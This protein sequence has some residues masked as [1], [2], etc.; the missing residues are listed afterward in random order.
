ME[1]TKTLYANPLSQL[2]GLIE[3]QHLRL[4]AGRGSA[5][6]SDI[7]AKRSMRIIDALPRHNIAWSCT[8]YATFY[9]N[10]LPALLEGWEREGWREGVH[11]VV[12]KQPPAS[13]HFYEYD[14]PYRA[15]KNY[16]NT[17][18][19][20][21]RA[22]VYIAS[23]AR[24]E[25]MAGG[26]YVHVV[27]DEVRQMVYDKLTRLLPALR[28][29]GR[30]TRSPYFLGTTFT[31]DYPDEFLGDDPW[32]LDSARDMDVGQIL[33]I[34]SLALARNTYLQLTPQDQPQRDQISAALAELNTRLENKRMDSTLF[35]RVSSFVNAPILGA[36]YF[37][38][39]TKFL[40]E[41]SFRVSV[42]SLAPQSGAGRA[43]YPSFN[44]ERHTFS[45]GECD[46]VE[47]PE[48]YRD[49]R[50]KAASLR[51][52]DP[53][54]PVNVTMDF[55]ENM[56]S[57]ILDQEKDGTIR[58]LKN[59]YALR[60]NDIRYLAE[61]VLFFLS[62]HRMRLMNFYY[63]RA[64]NTR[65][66]TDGVADAELF[67]QLIG[68][69]TSRGGWVV[70]PQCKNMRT[71]YQSEEFYLADAIFSG[72]IPGLPRILIDR[73][74]CHELVCSI[75]GARMITRTDAMGRTE[76]HKDKRSE[77]NFRSLDELPTKS[78]NLSDAFK[79]RLCTRHNLALLPGSQRGFF[80]DYVRPLA[81]NDKK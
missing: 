58:F 17:I 20:R 66:P 74:N 19:A 55:G 72:R 30:G 38:N 36:A 51:Y 53:E 8:T 9:S 73:Y 40:T 2:I 3:P 65:H 44:M 80:Q 34:L 48:D 63:D 69:D 71:I 52:Y 75:R 15:V 21:N 33:D 13:W 11:Y 77:K 26:S 42:L 39:L 1:E 16:K 54:A 14:P 41:E 43:F 78:T 67:S 18:I 29:Q 37:Q 79:Y 10:I 64:G 27:G 50:P 76:I 62:E 25:S 35:L 12:G 22:V 68:Q 28:G 46:E 61:E 60:P 6:T 70:I 59:F 7:L 4:I 47:I 45:D 5:K 23:L 57:L 31:T 56:L 32:I 24:L 81:K 49:F